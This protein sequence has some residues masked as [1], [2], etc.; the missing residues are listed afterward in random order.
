MSAGKNFRANLLRLRARKGL[1][2]AQLAARAG[3]SQG[4][5]A[6]IEN[7]VRGSTLSM[8]EKVSR[9]LR[10]DP[11]SMTLRRCKPVHRG[12]PALKPSALVHDNITMQRLARLMTQA[13]L[14]AQAGML[15]HQIWKL[16]TGKQSPTLTTLDRIAAALKLKNVGPLLAKPSATLLRIKKYA[17]LGSTFAWRGYQTV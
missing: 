14:G 15:Q 2:Q 9:A 6:A 1:T 3:T 13:K 17:Q 11:A 12:R 5:I 16:E 10:V 7:G 4:G 8:V